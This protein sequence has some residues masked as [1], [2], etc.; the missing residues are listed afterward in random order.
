MN[1]GEHVRFKISRF[2]LDDDRRDFD[3]AANILSLCGGTDAARQL[4]EYIQNPAVRIFCAR[5]L[6][7]D[8]R[9]CGIILIMISFESCD[10]LDIAVDSEFRRNGAAKALLEY[11][12][13][14]C[15]ERGVKE[16][17]LEVRLSNTAA[18]AFYER[19]G[20]EE[21]ARRRNYYSAPVE[22]A[23]VLRRKI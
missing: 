14:Y 13:R 9:L 21:I 6:L 4:N 20:F 10:I 5:S 11:A 15:K 2:N 1:D 17:L 23:A 7:S 3:A 12:S 18:R 19:A 16:Q 8:N 22:D